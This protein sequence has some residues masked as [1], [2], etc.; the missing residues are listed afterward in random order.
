MVFGIA[1]GGA[2]LYAVVSPDILQLPLLLGKEAAE[3]L[4]GLRYAYVLGAILA[5]AA[6][7]TS[8]LRIRHE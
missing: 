8:L 4:S 5:A 2:V 7:A 3:F 1:T 6:A